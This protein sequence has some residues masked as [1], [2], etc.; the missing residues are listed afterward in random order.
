MPA[1]LCEMQ[2][3]WCY[4]HG[5]PGYSGVGLHVS[6]SLA[7]ERPIFSHPEFNYERGRGQGLRALGDVEG[8]RQARRRY[9]G[10]GRGSSRHAQ[11][12]L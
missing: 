12:D 5:G 10:M 9:G 6:K 7:P 3:Y 8:V 1:A 2:G 11:V 4:W